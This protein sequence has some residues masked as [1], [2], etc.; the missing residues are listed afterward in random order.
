MSQEKKT[1]IKDIIKFIKRQTSDAD[2]IDSISQT[3]KEATL[4]PLRVLRECSLKGSVSSE[5][6]T[7]KYGYIQPPRAAREWLY[8]TPTSAAERPVVRISTSGFSV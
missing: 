4:R 1:A 8:A 6:L 2:L 5:T 3:L 7:T